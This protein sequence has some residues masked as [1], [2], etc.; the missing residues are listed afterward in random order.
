MKNIRFF[1]FLLSSSAVALLFSCSVYD[2]Q[3]LEDWKHATS[4]G[5]T[6]GGGGGSDPGTSP[7]GA[8]PTG[9]SDG[10]GG[11][12]TGGSGGSGGS[13]EPEP[14]CKGEFTGVSEVIL[15]DDFNRTSTS[16]QNDSG[17]SGSWQNIFNCQIFEFPKSTEN[18]VDRWIYP[19]SPLCEPE[20][21]SS[22]HVKMG[23]CQ[24]YV[25]LDVKFT[26]KMDLSEYDGIIFW[27]YSPARN[28]VSFSNLTAIAGLPAN[29][30]KQ[31]KLPF[32]PGVDV[33]EIQTLR[34]KP[35]FSAAVTDADFWI[36]DLSFYKD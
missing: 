6:D 34:L 36:D 26:A 19:P 3:W 15:L 8:D 5:G 9:G 7:G 32:L 1:P 30:W 11:T 2:D 24:P 10:S 13:T 21:S 28:G 16:L 29:E 31:V 18:N 4:T 23:E 17:I 12:E 25:S 20:E 14:V 35:D 33:S 27:G 22:L